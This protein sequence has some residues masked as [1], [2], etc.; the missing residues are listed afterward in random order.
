MS[1]PILVASDGSRG[2]EGALRTGL[3]LA[4]EQGRDVEVVAVLQPFPRYP[5]GGLAP[6]PEGYALYETIQA[7]SLKLAVSEQLR[8]LGDDAAGWPMSVEVGNPAATIARHAHERGAGL[9]VVGAGQRVPLDRWLGNETALKVVRLAT[10][11]VLVVPHTAADLPRRALVATDFSDHS[12][13]AARAAA[14]VLG[15]RPHV[16][17]AHM[18]W[19]AVEVEPFPS[20]EE[21]R[22]TYRRAAEARLEEIAAEL[23]AGRPLDVEC[24]VAEGDPAQELLGLASRLNVDVI[25]AGSH[26]FGFLGRLLLGSVSTRLIRGA[27]C[28]VLVAPPESLPQDLET[29]AADEPEPS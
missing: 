9:I 26:G 21:W 13:R 25:A 19:A 15:E 2:S 6:F 18:M 20:L 27:S 11:P 3:A 5:V 8:G 16:F 7:E 12:L 17:L 22:S 29:A 14:E 24:L 23:R 28:S 4:R 10:V 1:G